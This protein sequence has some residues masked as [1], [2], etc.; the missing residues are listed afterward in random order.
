MVRLATT[1]PEKRNK[2]AKLAQLSPLKTGDRLAVDAHLREMRF[3][4]AYDLQTSLDATSIMEGFFLKTQDFVVTHGLHYQFD[5]LGL[6]VGLGEQATH[7]I[8]YSLAVEDVSLGNLKF[9]RRK[10]FNETELA[11]LE[12]LIGV[13]FYPLR[14]AILYN[15]AINASLLDPLTGIGN[16]AAMDMSFEREIKLALRQEHPVALL[17]VDLDH[18]KRVNDS[19]GHLNGDRALRQV[20]K[21]IKQTLRETDQVFRYGG[22]EFVALL[23]NTD[24]NA[25]K[26]IAERIRVNVAMSPVTLDNED[27]FCTV[28]IGISVFAGSE[29]HE[30][31]FERADAAL[32]QAKSAGRNRV[33]SWEETSPCEFSGVRIA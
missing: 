17:L 18:F 10:K 33:E 16:R 27:L 11:V 9:F 28:S 21:S 12:M 6:D 3:K 29:T 5:N 22:E 26:L 20:V 2:Q 13:L 1:R 31:L 14:N 7:S 23:N 30:K 4:L 8:L 25:A 24:L 19:V 15:Q 32:Y